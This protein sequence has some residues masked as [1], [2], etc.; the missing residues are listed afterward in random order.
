MGIF[1]GVLFCTDLD[2][3]LLRSDKTVSEENKRAIAAFCREG[4]A[5]TFITG[6]MPF[7]V[8]SLYREVRPNAPIGCINGAGVYDFA[9]GR[10]L[11]TAT[12]PPAALTLVR[13]VE[14]AFPEVGIQ[15]NTFERVYFCKENDTMEI[16][17]R[18]T[19]LENLVCPYDEVR[20]PIAKI[21]FGSED[22]ATVLAIGELLRHHPMAADFSFIRSERTLCEILPRGIGKGTALPRICACLGYD[23]GRSVAIGDYDNDVSMLRAAGLGVAVANASEA[24]KRAADCLTVSNEEHAIAEVIEG[25]ASGRYRIPAKR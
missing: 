14:A 7:F 16:F 13:A 21:I 11:W 25:L 18:N 3:T 24:A 22:E 2:G 5:F 17:R 4:G 19:G 9:A 10:Y 23:V 12:L 1:D 20:E 15:V 6:R 8:S